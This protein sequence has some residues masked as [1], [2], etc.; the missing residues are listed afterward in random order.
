MPPTPRQIYFGGL[1]LTNHSDQHRVKYFCEAL[2]YF[3][4]IFGYFWRHLCTLGY[5]WLLLTTFE[6]FWLLWLLFSYLG[7]RLGCRPLSLWM[8]PSR[9]RRGA[10]WVE[11]SPHPTHVAPSRWRRGAT[12][13][14]CGDSSTLTVCLS[15]TR[16][17]PE[18]VQA[19]LGQD[20]RLCHQG[21]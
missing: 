20:Y 5:F 3:V 7:F 14:G 12:W 6:Y 13:V 10:T 4:D 19:Q 15:Q 21:V 2:D 11:L 1:L 8:A 9:W 16:P 17:E 18:I